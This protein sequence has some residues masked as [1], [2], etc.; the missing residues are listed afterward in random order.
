[1]GSIPIVRRAIFALWRLIFIPC[2]LNFGPVSNFAIRVFAIDNVIIFVASCHL[3]YL[4]F[5]QN[6]S[7]K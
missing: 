1:V 6:S 4:E 3:S 2:S 7:K 5:E